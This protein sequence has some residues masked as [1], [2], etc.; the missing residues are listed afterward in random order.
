MSLV[1]AAD[2]SIV[3]AVEEIDSEPD[4]FVIL[5]QISGWSSSSVIV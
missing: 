2:K 3:I 5:K 4:E 1:D